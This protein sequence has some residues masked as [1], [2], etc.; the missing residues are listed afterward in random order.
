MADF[1]TGKVQVFRVSLSQN[2]QNVERFMQFNKANVNQMEFKERFLVTFQQ[3]QGG[4]ADSAMLSSNQ[5]Y[6]VFTPH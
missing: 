3:L 2:D 1:D 4:A 6:L 5:T